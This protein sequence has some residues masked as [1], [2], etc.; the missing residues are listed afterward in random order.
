MNETKTIYLVS[1]KEPSGAAWLINCFLELGIK[2]DGINDTSAW[3]KESGKFI[4][5]PQNNSSKKWIPALST[6]ESFEFRKDIE[7]KWT[8]GWPTNKIK[9]HQIIYFIRDPR[10]SLF[11]SYKRENIDL[12]FSEFIGFLDS[13]TLL[14]KVDNWCLFN[15]CWLSQEQLEVFRFEDY[16]KD[17]HKLLRSILQYINVDFTDGQIDIAINASTFEMA[18]AAEKRYLKENPEDDLILLRAGKVESWKELDDNNR[19][20]ISL[21]ENKTAHLLYQFGYITENYQIPK[22]MI[23]YRPYFRYLSFFKTINY[24]FKFDE[25]I[26]KNRSTESYLQVVSF[27]QSL[28]SD[29]INR[30]K[31][32]SYRVTT[33]IESLSEFLYNSQTDTDKRFILLYRQYGNNKDRLLNV[34]KLKRQ[35][36]YLRKSSIFPILRFVVN[37]FRSFVQL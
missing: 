29:L 20:V 33:L 23:D 1:P 27:A 32:S 4:L 35:Y 36:N 5:N 22:E 25:D 24:D 10:D 34:F 18:A 9:G 14:N 8:H 2:T 31:L 11:S 30:T 6:H 37:K 26:N 21:I 17:A 16:K 12:S 7:I 13:N 3:R 15:E 28:D 19:N